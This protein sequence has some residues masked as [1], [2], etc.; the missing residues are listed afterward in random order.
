[1]NR[2]CSASE[3]ADPFYTESDRQGFS[4]AGHS[5][6]GFGID[7]SPVTPGL[8]ATG[9]C[10]KNIHVWK[11]SEGG[12]WK[13]DDRALVGHTKSVEDIQWSPN[14]A[15]VL[16]SCSVDKTI[17][18]FDIRANPSKACMLTVENAHA[19]DVNVISWNRVE[20]AYLLSGGDDGAIK[21]WD[22]R[23][24]K[25]GKPVTTFTHHEAPITSVE[26][27]PTDSS[28]FTVSGG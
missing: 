9:D 1:M 24:F 14:E 7:W 2:F 11:P 25:S 19:S 8:L 12:K 26:W 5:T 4:F 16:T 13:V 20:Q 15:T 23:Q 27:H 18:V 6:E 3:L 28:V 21:V 17:R 22:F 10:A